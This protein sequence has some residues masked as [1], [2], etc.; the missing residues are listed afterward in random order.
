M[1]YQSSRLAEKLRSEYRNRG[2]ALMGVQATPTAELMARAQMGRD[3]KVNVSAEAFEDRLHG[4]EFRYGANQGENI[5]RSQNG[6]KRAGGPNMVGPNMVGRNVGGS[7]MVGRNVGGPSGPSRTAARWEENR[8]GAS[9]FGSAGGGYE[10]RRTDGRIYDGR[11]YDGRTYDG[12]GAGNGGTSQNG[13]F[14]TG[15]ARNAS[16]DRGFSGGRNGTPRQSTGYGNRRKTGE[17]PAKKRT[18]TWDRASIRFEAEEGR[19]EEIKVERRR[20]PRMFVVILAFSTVMVMLVIMSVAQIYQTTREVSSLQ[21]TIEELKEN[22]D[23]LELQLDEKNDIRL[24]EQM[25]TTEYGMVK[26]DS[27][28]RQYLSMSDGERIDLL[29]TGTEPEEGG[30]GTML[31]SFFSVL[32]KFFSYFQ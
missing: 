10:K 9:S 8:S 27:V 28:Q 24:I 2:A 13:A 18:Q 14:R 23:D 19:P 16:F 29:D 22:I 3:P 32:G 7:N 15:G 25:A 6:S 11:T 26:E 20:L 30:L 17:G 21:N 4:R 1:A 5:R 12:R 31:S